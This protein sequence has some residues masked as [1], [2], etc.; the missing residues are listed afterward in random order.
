MKMVLNRKSPLA[1]RRGLLGR[2]ARSR[3]GAAALEFAFVAPIFFTLAFSILEGA[4]QFT[5]IALIENAASTVSRMIY[6]GQASSGSLSQSDLEKLV[7]DEVEAVVDC[8]GDVSIEVTSISSFTDIPATNATCKDKDDSNPSS[9]GYNWTSG[10]DIVYVR[11]CV[12]VDVL[13]PG[14]GL[15]LMLPK[16]GNDKYQVITSLVFRNEPF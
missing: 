4:W 6:T 11:I 2:F 12:T 8:N 1:T 7:C 5:R 9:P 3:S 13:T 10:D 15:G 14:L 16:T